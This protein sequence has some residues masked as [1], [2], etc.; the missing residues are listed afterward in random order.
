MRKSQYI[1]VA[2]AA[3]VLLG[4]GRITITSRAQEALD[5]LA[6]ADSLFKARD[7]ESAQPV[8][9]EAVAVAKKHKDTVTQTEANSMLARTYL[10]LDDPDRGRDILSRALATASPREPDG[11]ARYLSVRGRFEWQ[12]NDLDLAFKTFEEMYDYC[13]QRMMHE[14]AIDAAHMLAIV[15]DHEQQITWGKKGIAAAEKG[16]VTRWLGPLW[17]NLGAT[18]EELERWDESLAAYTRAR[19]Y[20]YEYGDEIYKLAADWAL[21]HIH[22]LRGEHEKAAEWL[23]PVLAWAERID[24][25]EWIGFASKELGQ[26]AAAQGENDKALTHLS[27]AKTLLEAEGMPNWDPTGWQELNDEITK[28]SE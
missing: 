25:K 2:L 5:V 11:W 6:K 28:L 20:H 4:A 27:R 13:S 23:R 7:Y 9:E 15:G 17:N 26:V 21:G 18:Y 14:E 16:E 8:Y 1:I 3:L 12:E 24:N 22:R 19:Q 10:I